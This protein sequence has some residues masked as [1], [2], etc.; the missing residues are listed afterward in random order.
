MIV[1][2]GTL[3]ISAMTFDFD[4]N[5]PTKPGTYVVVDYSAGGSLTAN[6][7]APFFAATADMPERGRLIHDSTA[8]QIKFV[9]GLEGTVIFVY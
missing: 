2:D 7:S 1:T 3:D 4:E 5:A 9:Y 8:K 6:P